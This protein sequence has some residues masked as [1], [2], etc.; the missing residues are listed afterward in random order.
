[1][2][3]IS[4]FEFG[5]L[6]KQIAAKGK[7]FW[8]WL[9]VGTFEIARNVW[10]CTLCLFERRGMHL[11]QVVA[12]AGSLA[13]LWGPGKRRKPPDNQAGGPHA[14]SLHTPLNVDWL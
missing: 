11:A 5:H 7:G 4:F 1:M 13:R 3:R 12:Y 9:A 6:L 2:C 10:A 8:A 14:R